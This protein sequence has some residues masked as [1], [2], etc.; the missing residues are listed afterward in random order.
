MKK[1]VLV[2]SVLMFFGLFTSCDNATDTETT[3][4]EVS[5]T[6]PENVVIHIKKDM[7]DEASFISSVSEFEGISVASNDVHHILTMSQETYVK[8]LE[9]KAQEVYDTFDKL[10]GADGF[11]EDIT[12]SES[13]RT[14]TVLVDREGF[15]ALSK[16]SKILQLQLVGAYGMSYQMFLEE[17]QKT[18]VTAVYSDSNEEA[19]K[20]SLPIN[21]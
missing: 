19:M 10:I 9:S 17:G 11:I 14:I 3:T 20:L 8:F 18:T 21:M 16:E 5:E 15:D 7:V 1:L 13:F 6:Q 4:S 12:Y 2:L